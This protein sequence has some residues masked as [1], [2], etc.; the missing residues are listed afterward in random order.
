M[1][2]DAEILSVEGAITI[3]V[4]TAKE[5]LDRGVTFVDVRDKLAFNAGH[6]PGAIH[7]DL[8]VDFT[9][10]R[11]S[12]F[13]DRNDEVVMSCWGINCPYGAH[14]SAK[15]VTWGYSQ[16]KYFAGGFPAWLA[17]G[18]SVEDAQD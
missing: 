13:V 2:R 4:D 3:D 15:A 18:Y 17:A 6:M 12:E 8:H 5:L 9:A 1:S 16:V 11:L 7:L 10:E 14:A